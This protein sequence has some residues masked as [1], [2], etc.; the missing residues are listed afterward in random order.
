MLVHL[1]RSHPEIWCNGEI[2]LNGGKVGALIGTYRQKSLKDERIWPLLEKEQKNVE[3]FIYKYAF[4]NQGKKVAGFKFKHDEFYLKKFSSV[5][6][7]ILDDPDIKILYLSRKNLLERYFSWYMVNHITNITLVREGDDCPVTK[8]VRLDPKE[9]EADFKKVFDWEQATRRDLA[10][11]RLLDIVY[12]DLVI[13]PE[14]NYRKICEFLGVSYRPM[15]TP[16]KKI[17]EKDVS[18]LIGNYNELKT[19]FRGTVY[20]RFFD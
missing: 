1:L 8:P 3:K 7:V 12:E 15:S 16:T 10:G 2:F 11:H 17:V 4:D 14:D 19:Y 13:N 9:C 6:K 18:Q 5:K 20:A